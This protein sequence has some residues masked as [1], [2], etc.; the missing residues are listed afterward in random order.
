VQRVLA[1]PGKIKHHP[2]RKKNFWRT[3][4]ISA[5]IILCIPI[6]IA[7]LLVLKDNDL[8][9]IIGLIFGGLQILVGAASWLFERRS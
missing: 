8:G 1:K 6:L 7:I 9:L 5:F 2:Y 3:F 4:R